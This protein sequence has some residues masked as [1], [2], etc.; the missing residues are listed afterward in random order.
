MSLPL[1]LPVLHLLVLDGGSSVSLST[2]PLFVWTDLARQLSSRGGGPVTA[3]ERN[4]DARITHFR[5][6]ASHDDP[7]VMGSGSACGPPSPVAY[8][9]TQRPEGLTGRTCMSQTFEATVV[10]ELPQQLFRLETKDGE[11]IASR[12]EEAKRLGLRIRTGQRVLAKKAGL[13]PGRGIIIGLA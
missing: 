10:A 13:D 12:S 4:R 2:D 8:R 9:R 1:Y 6:R 5:T 3:D 7:H 11:L